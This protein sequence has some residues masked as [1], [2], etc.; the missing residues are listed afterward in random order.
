[1]NKINTPRKNLK[2]LLKGE[3]MI[4]AAKRT[5]LSYPTVHKAFSG[6]GSISLD[7]ARRIKDQLALNHD[8]M[9]QLLEREVQR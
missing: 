6:K 9:M 8:E 4:S 2:A 1:M 5:G 7:T 3:T